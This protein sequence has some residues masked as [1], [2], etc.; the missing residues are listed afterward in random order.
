MS[1]ESSINKVSNIRVLFI[2]LIIAK[3]ECW[4]VFKQNPNVPHSHYLRTLQARLCNNIQTVHQ[5]NTN[6]RTHSVAAWHC[7]THILQTT[8]NN[9][10]R[11]ATGCTKSTPLPY[12][13]KR[14]THLLIHST[15]T[16]HAKPNTNTE[17]NAFNTC[18]TLFPQSRTRCPNDSGNF[19]MCWRAEIT[20][21]STISVLHW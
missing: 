20:L 12:G 1:I 6:I 8:Q 2:F 4:P 3:I 11:I 13:H 7:K 15:P 5:T 18:T 16:L 9:A 14:H 17:K 21:T 19:D 10:L